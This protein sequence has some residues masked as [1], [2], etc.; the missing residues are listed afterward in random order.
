MEKS[1]EKITEYFDD[2]DESPP[3]R[4]LS[5]LDE[6]VRLKEKAKG[7]ERTAPLPGYSDLLPYQ[8]QSK[9]HSITYK[10]INTG[11]DSV[12]LSSNHYSIDA[13]SIHRTGS[14]LQQDG[15]VDVHTNHHRDYSRPNTTTYSIKI[16]PDREGIAYISC[17]P[18]GITLRINSPKILTGNNLQET[19]DPDD[20]IRAVRDVQRHIKE[21]YSIETDLL[22]A[23]VSRL[24]IAR[25]PTLPS[26]CATYQTALNRLSYPRMHRT[27]H[28]HG[29]VT[30]NNG[31]HSIVCYDK[32]LSNK[33]VTGNRMRIEY[34]L[35]ERQKV[36]KVLNG[37]EV[38][39][40]FMLHQKWNKL[41]KETYKDIM[42]TLLDTS[43]LTQAQASQ[44][45][46][47]AG[48][49]SAYRAA[50]KDGKQSPYLKAVLALG[51]AKASQDDLDAL[52]AAINEDESSQQAYYFRQKTSDYE[53][54]ADA[55]RE[56][57]TLMDLYQEL[58]EAFIE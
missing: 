14:K 27:P 50:R 24:D 44:K 13:E 10:T 38:V 3:K 35:K 17:Y 47:G 30:L 40:P 28:R 51:L 46:Y 21:E 4:D 57:Q 32:T 52:N 26:P 36:S 15:Q 41:I 53:P 31:S 55:F 37:G 20:F 1:F 29:N 9:Q 48:L 16:K 11:I 23:V 49:V 2:R 12:N 7:G 18:T 39:T 45:S 8:G 19:R 33:N 25:T 22:H 56:G 42:E 34:Q 58:Q 54:Y 5:P 43:D 6:F